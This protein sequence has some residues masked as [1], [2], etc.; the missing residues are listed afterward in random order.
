VHF[1][2]VTAHDFGPLH[3]QSLELGPGMN[4]IYGANEAGRS[5]WHAALYAGLCGMRR[6]R[7]RGERD[8]AAFRDHHRPWDLERWSV[9][10]VVRLTNGRRIELH[11]DLDNR[12]GRAIDLDIGRDYSNE[13]I[14]DGSLDGSVWLGLN[15]R[16]FL[17]TACVRQA[18]LLAF[19]EDPDLL[20]EYLQRAAD[21]AGSDATAAR[22]LEILEEFRQLRV[23]Y[24][25]ESEGTSHLASQG[26]VPARP[27]AGGRPA[28]LCRGKGAWLGATSRHLTESE[29]R[30]SRG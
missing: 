5:S 2:I 26:A 19:L 22:A 8:D 3:E 9:T 27:A 20:Q 23:G 13:A 30:G 7:G 14:F 1:E 25:P 28:L 21:T 18:D 6:G 12:A 29:H 24:H 4:V 15:R 17:A 10:A 16:I 11:H